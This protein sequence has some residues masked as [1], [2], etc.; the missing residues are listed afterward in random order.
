MKFLFLFFL[1]ALFQISPWVLAQ[2]QLSVEELEILEDP[3]LVNIY[4]RYLHRLKCGFYRDIK[5]HLDLAGDELNDLIEQRE[6]EI[7]DLAQMEIEAYKKKILA[8]QLKTLRKLKNQN[9]KEVIKEFYEQ[10]CSLEKAL[11]GGARTLGIGANVIVEAAK[12]PISFSLN[13]FKG[14]FNAGSVNEESYLLRST[15]G[16][17]LEKSL[18]LL[19]LS[20]SYSLNLNLFPLSSFSAGNISFSLNPGAAALF[21]TPMADMLILNICENKNSH[22]AEE[23]TFCENYH[24]IKKVFTKAARLGYRLGSGLRGKNKAEDSIAEVD[25]SEFNELTNDN[26]CAYILKVKKDPGLGDSSKNTQRDIFRSLL[27]SH[28]LAIPERTDFQTPVANIKKMP[29]P[30]LAGMRNIIF[31]LSPDPTRL[32]PEVKLELQGLSELSLKLGREKKKLEKMIKAR[33]VDDCNERMLQSG[34]DYK[35]YLNDYTSISINKTRSAMIEGAQLGAIIKSTD[36]KWHQIRRATKLD[37][38]VVE[39]NSIF[40]LKEIIEDPTVMNLIIV[41]HTE[42]NL[43]KMVDS[44]LNQI[45]S[46]FFKNISP[47]IMGIAF[48]TC[49]GN[50]IL[51]NYE[52]QKIMDQAPSFHAKRMVYTVEEVD[53]M[54]ESGIAPLIGFKDFFITVDRQMHRLL[55]GNLLNQLLSNSLEHLKPQEKCELQVNGLDLKSGTLT[56]GLN[57]NLVFVSDSIRSI[58]SAMFDCTLLKTKNT[59]VL[60]NLNL[61]SDLVF[62]EKDISIRIVYPDSRTTELNMK[63]FYHNTSGVYM[64]SRADF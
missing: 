24:R 29:M 18:N 27:A 62:N 50:S 12:F 54:G 49:H 44:E 42:K 4:E 52:I 3:S 5:S 58:R 45:P 17:D 64:S 32:T 48:Y 2:D 55:K 63:H 8:D 60:F 14:L 21:L 47:S 30:A 16:K 46:N 40:K 26:I 51:K 59:L 25:Y 15:I 22:Y 43:G 35:S 33:S 39:S 37:W 41:T 23:I 57:Q 11:H 53:F 6:A 31:S 20:E 38:Q 19:L 34:F 28:E 56:L 10:G 1:V 36:K 7:I 9:P 61:E 13:F